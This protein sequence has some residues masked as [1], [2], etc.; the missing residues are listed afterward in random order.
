MQEKIVLRSTQLE[1]TGFRI[2]GPREVIITLI[3]T[4]MVKD[5]ED[6]QALH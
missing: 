5:G 6:L 2:T 1:L 3:G 4:R